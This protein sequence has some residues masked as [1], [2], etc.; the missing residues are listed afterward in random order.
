MK[1]L[2]LRKMIFILLIILIIIISI[3]VIITL[4]IFKT[5]SRVKNEIEL[6]NINIDI[7]EP[8]DSTC[9]DNQNEKNDD[10]LKEQYLNKK[11]VALTFDDGPSEYTSKLIDE[12]KKR[13]VK[14]TFFVLGSELEKYPD[15]L[16]FAY[17]TENEIGIHSYE[18]K[19]FTK[20]SENEII[21]QIT[22]TK[23]SI[24]KITGNNP[25][26]MRVPY[27]STN[28]R[29]N[30]IL[31]DNNLKDILWTVD[32]LDWKF[33]NVNKTYNYVLKKFN[34]N[35]IILMHD[36]FKTSIDA[37]TLIIDTLQ[38]KCYTFVTVSKFLEIK[39]SAKKRDCNFNRGK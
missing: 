16:K 18:H 1:V 17:D 39:E 5:K 32:S 25:T 4:K 34:G 7:P 23:N 13:D 3:S 35:D 37:A 9:N 11:L 33:K 19:L 24:F 20:L 2:S 27:G 6:E 26:L 12:L 38:S 28:K 14:A 36:S 15:T 30:T 31:N 21:F 22:K 29:I 10:F 8:D